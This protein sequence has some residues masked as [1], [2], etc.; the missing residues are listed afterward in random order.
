MTT[1]L[2]RGFLIDELT[3]FS[4]ARGIEV[5]DAFTHWFYRLLF[6]WAEE[7]EVP[8]DEFVDGA[9]ERQIDIFAI[10]IN[11]SEQSSTINLIQTKNTQGFS[12]NVV[13][14]MKAALDFIF[15]APR[16]QIEN[17]ANEKFK[18]KIIETRDVIRSYGNNNVSVYCSFVTLGDENDIADEAEENRLN[19]IREYGDTDIF[20]DFAFNFIGVNEL[21]R[22]VNLRRNRVRRV[23]WDLPIVYDA[24][25]ASIVEFDSAGVRSLLCT[26]TG[27]ELAKLAQV[28]P[29]DAIFDAN[30]RGNLGLG[31][32]VNKNI[33]ESS[34]TEDSSRF[35][36]FMNNGITMVCDGFNIVRDPDAPLVKITSLQI[37][38]GCQTTSSIRAAYEAGE[39]N[40]DVMLQLKLYESKDRK[41]IDKVVVA[42]NNQNAIGTRDLYANDEV[43]QLI[44]RS[45][46]EEFDL[47][48]ERKRGE[49]KSANVP[50][51]KV[52][53]LEKAGQAY[54]A[55]FKR[56]PTVSRA[57]KYKVFSDDFYLDVFQKGKPWQLAVAHELYKFAANRGRQAT[58]GLEPSDP[59]RNILNYGVFHI[60]RVFW[61]VIENENKSDVTDRI[62]LVSDIRS[63]AQ[64][65]V[66]SYNTAVEHVRTI[67][68]AN[69][70]TLVNLNNYFKKSTSQQ[71][72]NTYLSKIEESRNQN[73]A[74]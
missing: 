37:I 5:D 16:D 41:F 71:N 26:V 47:Y 36:W 43:Q 22:I 23:S 56:Q 8:E 46:E 38:N 61:W 39:L 7:D 25:R 68:E 69:N 17:L 19:V 44:Q 30:V 48:Y 57:Q 64:Y 27:I 4:K 32:R 51:T 1:E 20:N 9:G 29:R 42:T 11:D 35:F 15:K 66:D 54:I 45:I 6:D 65:I 12:A 58:K 49:A 24:N 53:D 21:D 18:Q 34:A 13:S 74:T 50:S 67:V 2:K 60:T 59:M 72:I 28:E 52:I 31:G 40:A 62:K 55:V 3:E 63:N 70:E 73:V 10:A 33:Y 14:L